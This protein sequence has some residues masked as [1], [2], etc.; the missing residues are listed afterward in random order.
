MDKASKTFAKSVCRT[1][2][3]YL[4][5]K[6]ARCVCE[7]PEAKKLDPRVVEALVRFRREVPRER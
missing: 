5:G 7:K 2:G 4:E 1:C 3:G 6:T